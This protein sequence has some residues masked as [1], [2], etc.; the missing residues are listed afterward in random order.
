MMENGSNRVRFGPFVVDLRTHELWK[1]GIRLRLSGQPFQV[2]EVLLETPGELVTRDDLRSRIWQDDTFVDFSHGLNAAVNKL[3]EALSDSAQE[4]RYIET[5]P[6]R[7]YRF[8]AKV[9]SVASEPVPRPAASPQPSQPPAP[10]VSRLPDPVPVLSASTPARRIHPGLY[11]LG[12]L[13]V[14][15]FAALAL[16]GPALFQRAISSVE[17]REGAARESSFRENA[18][19]PRQIQPLTTI[20]DST[21]FPSFSSDGNYVAFY[22]DGIETGSAGIYVKQIGTDRLLQLTK[23]RSDCCPV[24]SPDKHLIAFSRT[25]ETK[26]A[27]IYVI[28]SGIDG[29]ATGPGS[30]RKLPINGARP[31]S[32]DYLWRDIDWSPDGKSIAFDGGAGI[33]L[34]SVEN[35]SVRRV[36]EVPPS[37]EDWGPVFSADGKHLLFVRSGGTGVPDEIRNL[38]FDSGEAMLITSEVGKIQGPPQWSND[39]RSVIFSSARNGQ[40]NLWRVSANKRD[41]PVEINDGGWFPAVA[42]KGYRLAYQRLV[43]GLNIWELDLSQ[44]NPGD[45]VLISSISPTDQGPGPQF[46]PD[47][48]KLAFMSDR[49]GSLEIWIADRDGDNAFQLTAV[50]DAGTPR[51]SP[52]GKAIAFDARGKHTRVVYSI[53]VDGGTPQLLS[54]DSAGKDG[55]CPSWSRDGK[56]VYFASASTGKYQVWKVPAVGGTSIQ[57]TKDGG[58]AALESPDGKFVYYAKT[59]YSNPAIWRIPVNGGEETAVSPTIRPSSWA[60]WAVTTQGIIF[61][62]SGDDGR[63]VVSLYDFATHRVRKLAPLS[64][65]PFWLTATQ[66][67]K[68]IAFDKPG[69]QQSQIMLVENFR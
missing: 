35:H 66:D 65:A 69:W 23:S 14:A 27:E 10:V 52:D 9:Q 31:R 20:S 38:D 40:P 46:S 60:S 6:R 3:R 58:H 22:R 50:G 29:T 15:T 34:V 43:H 12:V 33:F 48:K 30:E 62:G 13:A 25:S 1:E 11:V 2:L 18:S 42:R 26:E 53:P 17:A 39:E 47:G 37:A 36:T 67:G 56:F 8:I 54:Q 24:W 16:H 19:I 44:K 57:I 63:P 49:S 61:A 5:L 59:S 45:R 68:T 4:P 51:W 32:G 28:P 64:I 7:G 55:V 41:N 21:G